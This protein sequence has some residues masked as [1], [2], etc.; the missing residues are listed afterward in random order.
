MNFMHKKWSYVW[1]LIAELS[2]L[3][4]ATFMEHFIILYVL[5]A[6]ALFFVLGTVIASIWQS[7]IPRILAVAFGTIAIVSGFVWAI[8]GVN[9]EAVK[10]AFVVCTFSY[11]A[12]ALISIIAMFKNVFK[13]R[14]V[15]AN[16]IVGSICIYLLIGMFFTFVYAGIDLVLPNT[17]TFAGTQ[18]FSLDNVPDYLYFSYVTLTTTGYGDIV[19][20]LRFSRLIAVLEAITGQVYLVV[21]VASLVG[22][23]VSNLVR[24][25]ATK[26]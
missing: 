26:S 4:M 7:L 9:D 20:L 16:R 6:A 3:F 8:P 10:T 19:P 22:V 13:S 1:V 25:S 24:R 21:M 14:E 17:F 12:F 5:F 23:H 2:L 15:T 18:M 11:A